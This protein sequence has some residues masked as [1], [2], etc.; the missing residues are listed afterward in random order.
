MPLDNV[1]EVPNS[2]SLLFECNSSLI[3]NFEEFAKVFYD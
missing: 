2:M 3:M 1:M